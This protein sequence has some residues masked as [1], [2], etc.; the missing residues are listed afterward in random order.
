MNYE[1]NMINIIK[2]HGISD[3]YPELIEGTSQWYYCQESKKTFCDLYEAEEI[4]KLGHNFEGMNCHLIHYPEGTVHS[5]F[6][7]KS[8]VYIEKPIWNNGKFNFLVVNFDLKVIQIYSYE[9]EYIR[10][11]VMQELPLSITPDCYNLM[12]KGYPLMLCRDAN[13]GIYEIIWPESKKIV[14]GK[15]E[16]LIVR[17]GN[18]L[19]FSRWYEDPE[20]HE[21]VIVRDVNTG[22]INE[23][24]D[25]YLRVL[26]NGIYWRI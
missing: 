21:S 6:E 20:Y 3:C 4:V 24:F 17:D 16:S 12:L 14:I 1:V 13:D 7:M 18:D 19:Y 11:S 15:T 9:P 10:L 23:E 8:N 22:A 25:G 2:I 26:P 5:P